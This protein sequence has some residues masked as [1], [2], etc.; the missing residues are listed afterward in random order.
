MYGAE[1]I[2]EVYDSV[3]TL[4]TPIT[5]PIRI[6][7]GKRTY[8][9][10]LMLIA[11]SSDF[12]AQHDSIDPQALFIPPQ[13]LSSEPPHNE[14]H[15]AKR[16]KTGPAETLILPVEA[17]VPAHAAPRVAPRRQVRNGAI[18]LSPTGAGP[19][20]SFASKHHPVAHEEKEVAIESRVAPRR[21]KGKDSQA[22]RDIGKGKS[23]ARTGK[24]RGNRRKNVVG[25]GKGKET[26]VANDGSSSDESAGSTADEDWTLE[27]NEANIRQIDSGGAAEA[28]AQAHAKPAPTKGSRKGES[29][30][31]LNPL[32]LISS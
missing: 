8:Q 31:W 26:L 30:D 2:H 18:T 17:A 22:P 12:I 4:P 14:T 3:S 11:L 13:S 27:K 10:I 23:A 15:A 24:G 25:K 32:I 6:E 1:P 9:N 28:G 29:I 16:R 19:S 21:R 5:E 20:N 7:T